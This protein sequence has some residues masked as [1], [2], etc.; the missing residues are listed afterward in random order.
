MT[1]RK[2]WLQMSDSNIEQTAG[3]VSK[4]P[5]TESHGPSRRLF[6]RKA[7]FAGAGMV[8]LTRTAARSEDRVNRT[9]RGRRVAVGRLIVT[10][11]AAPD[12][13]LALKPGLKLDVISLTVVGPDFRT[14]KT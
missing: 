7:A 6:L 1:S 5:E 3:E 13:R 2:G 14:P 9:Q 4:L 8:G 12:V 11:Q 10:N